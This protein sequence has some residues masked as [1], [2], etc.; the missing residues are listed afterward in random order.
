MLAPAIN[1]TQ[2]MGPLGALKAP[3]PLGLSDRVSDTHHTYAVIACLRL[4]QYQ[5]RNGFWMFR[6]YLWILWLSLTPGGSKA[7]LPMCADGFTLHS[8]LE[9]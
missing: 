6:V 8:S 1:F 2:I 9:D 5:P 4:S 3:S 7:G